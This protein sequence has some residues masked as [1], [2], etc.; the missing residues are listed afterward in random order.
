M[1]RAIRAAGPMDTPL[2]PLKPEFLAMLVKG[3][4][5]T[6][7]SCDHALNPSVMRAVGSR[8]DD[9]GRRITAYLGRA[10]SRQLLADI[11]STGRLAAV[12]SQPS[13][14]LT[15][16]LK[17]RRVRI[18]EARADDHP[19]PQSYLRS[20]EQEVAAVGFAP[21]YAQALL[22]YAPDELVA[23]EFEPDEAYDQTPGSKA[24]SPL[25]SAP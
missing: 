7:S 19:Y 10:Q 14:H 16:Q 4:S 5:L 15:L 18:R 2:P 25:V 1:I 3:V 11:A 21:V 22:A 6:L 24:G 17:S 12:F 20:M 9:G 13:T 23:V 8:I